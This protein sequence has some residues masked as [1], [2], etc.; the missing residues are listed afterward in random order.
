MA[1]VG[2]WRIG[3]T[4]MRLWLL[5]RKLRN[6]V[7]HRPPD[8]QPDDLRRFRRF[9]AAAAYRRAARSRRVRGRVRSRPSGAHPRG[10]LRACGLARTECLADDQN[11]ARH[12]AS[13]SLS[14]SR[15]RAAASCRSRRAR[16]AR[17]SRHVGHLD[18]RL[19][20]ATPCRRCRTS[21]SSAP[22]APSPIR[23]LR[24]VSWSFTQ[25]TTRFWNGSAAMP[26]AR[27]SGAMP[28]P[29]GVLD[30]TRGSLGGAWHHPAQSLADPALSLGR[31][32][33]AG[34]RRPRRGQCRPANRLWP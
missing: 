20:R 4:E 21:S 11:E 22:I 29:K 16:R 34:A 6:L 19:S 31:A 24:G 10:P 32:A 27:S 30:D 12:C 13:G 3:L 1:R 26:H 18:C 14:R 5:R 17:V 8:I 2:G 9:E 33:A 28:R 15:S 23:P 25:R 7:G